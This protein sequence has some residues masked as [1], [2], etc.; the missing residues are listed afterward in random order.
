MF[1]IRKKKEIDIF[2]SYVLFSQFYPENFSFEIS[3]YR[4]AY[5]CITNKKTKKWILLWTSLCLNWEN[6]NLRAEKV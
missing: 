6:K 4:R 3:L 2:S 1:E 5:A